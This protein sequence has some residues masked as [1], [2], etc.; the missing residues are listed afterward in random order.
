[1]SR[2][3]SPVCEHAVPQALM[4]LGQASYE[5]LMDATGYS[6]LIVRQSLLMLARDGYS[7]YTEERAAQGALE[8]RFSLTRSGIAEAL[9]TDTTTA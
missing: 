1:M 9:A 4:D 6:K 7:R 3:S 8:R 2:K 5:Q